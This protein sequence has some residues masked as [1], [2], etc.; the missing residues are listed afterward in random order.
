MLAALVLTAPAASSKQA[1][2]RE[3]VDGKRERKP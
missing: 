2:K 3:T 1:R